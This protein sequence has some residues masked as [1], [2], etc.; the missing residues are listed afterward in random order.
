VTS[1]HHGKAYAV[2]NVGYEILQIRTRRIASEEARSEDYLLGTVLL[3]FRWRPLQAF[4]RTA[5]AGN[6]SNDL[7][8]F[9]PGIL[10]EYTSAFLYGHE[11]FP[12]DAGSLPITDDDS[13][14]SQYLPP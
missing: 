8:W 5:A 3:H 2:L 9:V 6:E 4:T 13:D 10:P 1:N 11:A 7:Q 14:L 12:A